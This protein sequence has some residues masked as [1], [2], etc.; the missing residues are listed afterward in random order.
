MVQL[1]KE[2]LE[3]TANVQLADLNRPLDFIKPGEFDVVLSSL[4]LDYIKDW[5]TL[6]KEFYRILNA[7]GRFVL[8]VHHPFFLDLKMD[9]EQIEI[10]ESYFI[11]QRVEEDWLPFG[12]RIPSYRR[13]LSSVSSALWDA[14]FLIEKIVE[15]KPTLAWKMEHPD[16]YQKLMK[17]PVF[18]CFSAR[19]KNEF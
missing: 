7:T 9:P 15:P 4:T 5:Q 18:I 13:P 2:K 11:V 8:S 16:Y 17:H 12:L 14:G 1:A 3:G 6:F 10:A 19:K